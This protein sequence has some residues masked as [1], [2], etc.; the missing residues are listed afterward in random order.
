MAVATLL[1]GCGSQTPSTAGVEGLTP[2]TSRSAG[3][4]SPYPT[5]LVGQGLVLQDRSHGPQLC[6]GVIAASAPAQCGGPDIPNWDWAKVTGKKTSAG[7]TDGSYVVI[8]HFDPGINT[9]TL[10]RPPIPAAAYHGPPISPEPQPAL[11]G[12]PCS[13]PPGGWQVVDP[14][15]TTDDSFERTV[16]R[17]AAMAGYAGVW[18]DQSRSTDPDRNDP[19]Q[20]ILNVA[21]TH[22]LPAREQELRETWGG[23]LC[24][25]K[26]LHTEEELKRIQGEVFEAARS[27]TLSADGGRD[28]VDLRLIYDDGTLQKR[29]DATYGPGVVRVS[30][31]LRPYSG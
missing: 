10:T 7:T 8:G 14:A 27:V 2:P 21:F 25:S 4:P 26:G 1:A 13:P 29:F 30:S 22:D 6:L 15:K 28:G 12:T 19:K 11:P 17:A 18:V 3:T 9:F 16:S 24:V 31:A 20:L 23:L 5:E